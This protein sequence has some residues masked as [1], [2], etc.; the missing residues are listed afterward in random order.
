MNRRPRTCQRLRSQHSSTEA[1]QTPDWS[2]RW[3]HQFGELPVAVPARRRLPLSS[4]GRPWR[5]SGRLLHPGHE[6][7]G[8][9]WRVEVQSRLAGVYHY[10]CSRRQLE[11][12]WLAATRSRLHRVQPRDADI[13]LRCD[14]GSSRI[15]APVRW[16][17]KW[18]HGNSE[19]TWVFFLILRSAMLS[20]DAGELGW[21]L[22][23]EEVWR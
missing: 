11:A 21:P 8:A 10:A 14:H 5:R 9:T 15:L 13:S 1:A 20:W 23:A 4:D 3:L 22:P 17:V 12:L 16:Y 19:V 18:V 6:A 7:G 2:D